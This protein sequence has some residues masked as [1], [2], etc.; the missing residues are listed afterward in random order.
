MK[1]EASGHGHDWRNSNPSCLGVSYV[2]YY[3]SSL[4]KKIERKISLQ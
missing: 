3:E 4:N 1:E 2:D